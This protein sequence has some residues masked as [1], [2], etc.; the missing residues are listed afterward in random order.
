M[1]LYDIYP[2]EEVLEYS[3]YFF[4]LYFFVLLLSL[5]IVIKLYKKRKIKPLSALEILEQSDYSRAKEMAFK[6]SFYGKTI[7][8]TSEQEIVFN[9]LKE[10]LTSFKYSPDNEVLTQSIQEEIADFL[11][12]LRR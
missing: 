10:K 7:L 2:I 8:K 4:L 12:S 11:T 3:L 5:Y 9:G 1:E 6:L